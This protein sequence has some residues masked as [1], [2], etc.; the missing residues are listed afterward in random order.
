MVYENYAKEISK[1]RESLDK[2]QSK[3]DVNNGSDKI[4][5]Y[6]FRIMFENDTTSLFESAKDLEEFM[7]LLKPEKG[8][9]VRAFSS[10]F[11]NSL[12]T[13]REKTSSDSQD[14][15]LINIREM[16]EK[17]IEE[18]NKLLNIAEDIK[19]NPS[20]I[21]SK[22]ITLKEVFDSKEYLSSISLLETA[23][24]QLNTLKDKISKLETSISIL[25]QGVID[26]RDRFT[27]IFEEIKKLN[28]SRSITF[29]DS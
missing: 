12:E 1:F 23:P 27:L 24:V 17:I 3:M 8:V 16:L 10:N 18:G 21:I 22:I 20:E 7:L 9:K 19:S 4:S 14:T 29:H 6:K 25:E 26:L 15:N 5:R 2:I 28:S 11:Y 13:L